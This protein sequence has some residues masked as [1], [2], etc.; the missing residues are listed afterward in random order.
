MKVTSLLTLLSMS[1][2]GAE[3]EAEDEDEEE[4]EGKKEGMSSFVIFDATE[5]LSCANLLC[6]KKTKSKAKSMQSPT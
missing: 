6:K 2:E 4:E 3:E 5:G 1:D